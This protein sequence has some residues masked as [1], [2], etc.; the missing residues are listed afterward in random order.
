MI[1]AVEDGVEVEV[2]PNGADLAGFEP[3]VFS[4]TN[5]P[6]RVICVARL[7]ERKGQHHL[8]QAV[9]QLAEEGVDVIA[10]LLGTGD[11]LDDYLRLAKHLGIAERIEF[12]G[13]VPREDLPEYYAKADVFVLPSFNEGMSLA[14]LE[15][16]AAGLPLVVSRTG[17]TSMLVEEGVNGYSFD[18]AHIDQLRVHLRRL[19]EERA[20]LRSMGAASRKRARR[21][22]WSEIAKQYLSLFNN[23]ILSNAATLNHE[24]SDIAGY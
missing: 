10:S 19:S 7:I 17:G 3:R 12:H 11:A 18:W 6:F 23:R 20:L 1:H 14:A 2:V 4:S 5:G 15:A 21:Y 16:M 22:A 8:I 24:T 13:Y 9:K